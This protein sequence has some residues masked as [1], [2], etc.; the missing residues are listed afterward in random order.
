MRYSEEELKRLKA[1]GKW[2]PK[3]ST[4]RCCGD[5]I[6]SSYPGEFVACKCG[7]SFVDQTPYY[8]R[9]GGTAIAEMPKEEEESED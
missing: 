4:V 2:P 9:Y 5:T 1:E 8:S 6:V 3:P 7:K